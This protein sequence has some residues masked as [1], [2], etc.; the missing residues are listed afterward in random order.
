MAQRVQRLARLFLLLSGALVLTLPLSQA[1][2]RHDLQD[3]WS[4]A[5][6]IG[7]RNRQPRQLL[8]KP[9]C[10]GD[11]S[12]PLAEPDV[13]VIDEELKAAPASREELEKELAAA[14]LQLDSAETKLRRAE[15]FKLPER[16]ELKLEVLRLSQVFEK[17]SSRLQ[18]L[19]PVQAAAS[20][21]PILENFQYPK[22]QDDWED[23]IDE[24]QDMTPQQKEELGKKLG[25]EGR[26][27]FDSHVARIHE[28]MD[29]EEAEMENQREIEEFREKLKWERITAMSG[30]E[31]VELAKELGPAFIISI[32]MVG[33]T[34]WTVSLS[35]TLWAFHEATGELPNWQDLASMD[36]GRMAGVVAGLL[37][38]AVLLKP[39][40]LLIAMA[41]TPWTRENVMPKVPWFKL[42]KGED[43]SN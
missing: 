32:V 20:T 2:H 35:A 12:K 5:A 31:R 37:S 29:E 13:L 7:G 24:F 16:E 15:A 36:T 26:A 40:R 6:F 17:V 25:P 8:Q 21:S 42:Q 23:Y 27:E 34:Y 22:T 3:H 28:E 38:L 19:L 39:L 33:V 18:P 1:L 14:Q 41:I 9:T 10:R 30:E 4:S 11:G 43:A